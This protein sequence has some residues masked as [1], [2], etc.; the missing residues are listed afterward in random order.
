METLI[1]PAQGAAF[2]LARGDSFRI[3]DVEGR[4]VSD[5][6][7]FLAQDINERFS[8]GNTRKL[9]NSLLLTTGA[10]LYSTRC[11]PL[12]RIAEDTVK[13]HDIVSSWCS[14]YDYPIRF[15]VH[16]HASCLAILSNVLERFKIEEYMVPEPF[17]VFMN[18]TFDSTTGRIEINEPLST[19]GD[20][21]TFDVMTD[22]I[23]AMTACP[24]D[25]NACNGGKSTP[26][27]VSTVKTPTPDDELLK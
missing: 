7:I 26:I 5:L 6:V 3:T 12:L 22:C 20:Y 14:P 24:Q 10:I 2:Q 18:T 16:D 19:A 11:T 15:G 21:I 17:N 8:P 1:Q 9:N 13:R 23:V 4:Q 27:A 25:Q